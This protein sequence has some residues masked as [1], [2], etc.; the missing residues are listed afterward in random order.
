[1]MGGMSSPSYPPQAFERAMVFVDGSNLFP[2]LREAKLRVRSFHDISKT[3]CRGRNL[4]R[5]YLYTCQEKLDKA[6]EEHGEESF[7]GCRIVL[8]ESVKLEN[9]GHR[10]KGVDALLV[11]DLVYHAASRNCQFAAVLSN[12][13][14]FSVALKRVEDFGCRTGVL[15]LIHKAPD[16]LIKSCDDYFY[17]TAAELVSGNFA[18]PK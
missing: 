10:E 17:L 8:G 6:I 4:H 16:K 13:L 9:G 3:A 5:V 2:R 18:T 11:A 15:S 7:K 14:D 12:D 1:M